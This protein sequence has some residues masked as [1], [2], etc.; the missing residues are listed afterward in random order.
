MFRKDL[1]SNVSVSHCKWK[2]F[3]IVLFRVLFL[4]Y[5][6]SLYNH[7]FIPYSIQP[8]SSSFQDINSI[9][10]F[11]HFLSVDSLF[12][13][14]PARIWFISGSII[15][16]NPLSSPANCSHGR[17][18]EKTNRIFFANRP[19]VWPFDSD[20]TKEPFRERVIAPFF[21][22]HCSNNFCCWHLLK[23]LVFSLN[24][25]TL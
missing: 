1:Y 18:M 15:I 5:K 23:A 22:S 25:E 8:Y 14:V 9:I 3:K 2:L 19:A 12:V 24:F 13:R 10:N 4:N 11:F 7:H 21:Y 16:V 17:E 6:T 20:Q